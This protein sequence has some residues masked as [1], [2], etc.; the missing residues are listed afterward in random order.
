MTGG[1]GVVLNPE[2]I[3]DKDRFWNEQLSKVNDKYLFGGGSKQDSEKGV[4]GSH[5]YAVLEAWEEVSIQQSPHFKTVARMTAFLTH[6][7]IL[8]LGR[9]T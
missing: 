8:L 5:A 9:E 6:P 2:D 1:V 7:L 3:M 4:V